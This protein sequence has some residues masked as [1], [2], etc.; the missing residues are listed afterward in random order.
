MMNVLDISNLIIVADNV[1]NLI[2]YSKPFSVEHTSF[3]S[4]QHRR[5][6]TNSIGRLNLQF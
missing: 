3:Y 6:N 1:P 4:K 5:C 2:V